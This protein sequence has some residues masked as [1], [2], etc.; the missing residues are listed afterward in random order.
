MNP[1]KIYLV[2]LCCFIYSS[3]FSQ[4]IPATKRVDWS[5][6]GLQNDYAD[7]SNV[8]DVTTFG[9]TGNGTTND[10]PAILSAINSLGGHSGVVFFPAGNYLLNST[11]NLPDS[12]TLKGAGADVTTFTFDLG[13]VTGNCINITKGQSNSFVAAVNG[14]Q[15]ESV[16]IEIA[17]ASG[18]SAGD[19]AEIHE[20]NGTWD[21]NPAFWAVYSVGQIVRIDSISGNTLYIQH[22]LRINYDSTLNVAMQKVIPR[23]NVGL[24]CF[25][26]TRTDS[27]ALNVNY[28]IYY[29]YAS[30]CWMRGVESDH[31][32]GAHVL[33]EAST[34]LEVTGCYFHHSYIYDGSN[35]KGYGVVMGVHTGESKIE[36]NIFRHLRHAMMVK[37]GANGN[38]YAYNYSIEPTRTEFPS[39]AGPD[40][41]LHGH[42]PFAN[43]FEGNICQNLMIDQ[44]WGPSGPFNTFFRNRIELYGIIMSSG[45]VNSDSENFV[46]NDITGTGFAQGNYIL[47]GTGH[48]T[49][50][51]NVLG[52]IQP[53]GTSTLPDST[54]YLNA[55][56]SFWNIANTWPDIGTPNPTTNQSI[57]ARERF[58]S[59]TGFTLCE[60]PV[61]SGTEIGDPNNLTTDIF[62][63]PSPFADELGINIRD[64]GD[65]IFEI[66]MIDITGKIIF[67]KSFHVVPGSNAVRIDT[68]SFTSGIY[69]LSVLNSGSLKTFRCIKADF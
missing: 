46:G 19:Y 66:K 7:T 38:V 2:I 15:K 26:I 27:A 24:E 16:A 36:N 5:Y 32:I 35:T 23:V 52:T 18:F 14:Y 45:T 47:A 39:D 56:P 11:L 54:Y 28:G 1:R 17:N 20:D 8:A 13:G 63:S 10:Y 55:A 64:V 25:K 57:P 61:I 65:E 42:Y 31:S 49:Y 43:L 69:F 37:Q 62:L 58:I 29:Y 6:A 53:P 44:A 12:V 21:T 59:G 51:N 68:K 33:A 30:D 22:P 9:A 4:V 40:I 50:G 60:P 3:G 48:F 67:Q 41:A 34:S